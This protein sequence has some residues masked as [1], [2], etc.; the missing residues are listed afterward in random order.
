VSERGYTWALAALADDLQFE[1]EATKL[2]GR[3]AKEAADPTIKE[4][5]MELARGEAGHVR[6][7]RHMATRLRTAETPVVFFCP[8]C[9][10]EIDFGP[11][12]QDGAKGKCH[13]CPGLF[14]LR[15]VDG[16]WALE[17]LAP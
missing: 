10:W 1:Q 11:D 13:M 15:L 5:F 2:Y 4:L 17:R 14:A 7:I 9:G 16:D 6:G 3:F 12:P 8:I